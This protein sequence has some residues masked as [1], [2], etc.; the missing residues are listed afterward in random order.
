MRRLFS[1][2]DR[3][4]REAFRLYH[5]A[6][7]QEMGKKRGE[8]TGFQRR[9]SGNEEGYLEDFQENGGEERIF[10][11]IENLPIENP[12]RKARRIWIGGMVA[13]L[14][15]V[16]AVCMVHYIGEKPARITRALQEVYST[17]GKRLESG[18]SNCL[19]TWEG[20]VYQC[21]YLTSE[22]QRTLHRKGVAYEKTEEDVFGNFTECQV[23]YISGR[24]SRQFILVE[25]QTQQVSLGKF[26]GYKYCQGQLASGEEAF[27]ASDG[28][29]ER[30]NY[31]LG[32]ILEKVMGIHSPEDIR[33]VTLE[34]SRA[35]SRDNPEKMVA[36]WTKRE[37]REW[38]WQF[39]LGKHE[40][41]S[42]HPGG[43][44]T[45]EE[46][47]RLREQGVP[48]TYGK[49]LFGWQS[50]VL[51]KI[52]EQAFYLEIEN[53]QHEI[54]ILG[55]ILEDGRA[56][57]W[58]EPLEEWSSQRLELDEEA[59]VDYIGDMS[60][61][62]RQADRRNGVILLSGEDQKKLWEAMRKVLD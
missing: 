5:S 58:M 62:G 29:G 25:D 34:R 51:E 3:A 49:G 16:L 46:L 40:V 30:K 17:S 50:Q 42:P 43:E 38:F 6:Q 12:R 52:P 20:L 19:F 36:M 57:L 60:R 59:A 35:V 13:V 10:R 23:Y 47:R 54:F 22:E 4:I 21:H 27:G 14:L 2:G 8:G 24:E 15:C 44:D 41:W 26:I 18:T 61:E 56:E 53:K 33:T 1:K 7:N 28:S 37:D 32:D 39:F 9:I 31:C 45:Q 11:M 48:I 55:L